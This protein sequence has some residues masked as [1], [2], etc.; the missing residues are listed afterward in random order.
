MILCAYAGMTGDGQVIFEMEARDEEFER[1]NI[2]NAGLDMARQYNIVKDVPVYFALDKK[3]IKD[4]LK[5][6]PV[7]I[8][9]IKSV[10]IFGETFLI[11]RAL[12]Y[13]ESKKYLA[14]LIISKLFDTAQLVLRSFSFDSPQEAIREIYPLAFETVE[15]LE[16][17]YESCIDGRC[18]KDNCIICSISYQ[19]IDK[20][21]NEYTYDDICK[22]ISYVEG[23]GSAASLAVVYDRGTYYK[24]GGKLDES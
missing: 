22:I 12:P 17:T 6:T 23:H 15:S 4:D 21:L 19:I 2:N 18:G 14:I 24:S 7:H 3:E 11:T 5:Y 9:P 20:S 10:P 1:S 8:Q 13:D 16:T